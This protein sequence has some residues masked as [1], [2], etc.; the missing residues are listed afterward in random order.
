[1]KLNWAHC[2]ALV[3]R[4][5]GAGTTGITVGVIGI[6]LMFIPVTSIMGT[7]LCVLA[8]IIL[9]YAHGLKDA[10]TIIYKSQHDVNKLKEE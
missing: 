2:P 3:K 10:D 4:S 7:A 5:R 9:G 6:I 8:L 1:M